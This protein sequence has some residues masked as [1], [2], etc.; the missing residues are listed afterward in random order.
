[1]KI[2]TFLA[3]M[4]VA[5]VVNAETDKEKIVRLEKEN[6]ELREDVARMRQVIAILQ[7][8]VEALT[9]P[10]GDSVK[11]EDG[12][13]SATTKPKRVVKTVDSVEAFAATIPADKLP[14]AGS[15]AMSELHRAV[16]VEWLDSSVTGVPVK[17]SG[18]VSRVGIET[19]RGEK[20]IVVQA[21]VL[22]SSKRVVNRLVD[23]TSISI[24][25]TFPF[26]RHEDLSK[27]TVGATCVFTGDVT[28]AVISGGGSGIDRPSVGVLFKLKEPEIK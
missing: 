17:L 7:R 2:A 9:K 18:K 25:A 5:G 11:L 16:F 3:V 4:M 26:S 28:D 23:V 15:K 21:I 14:P 10:S 27:I 8:R 20:S 22:P 12:N 6:Y 24:E 19:R 13:A 1:M